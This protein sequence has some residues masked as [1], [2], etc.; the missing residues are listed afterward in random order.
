MGF[1][2]V[3]KGGTVVDGTGLPAVRTDVGIKNGKVVA[4]GNLSAGG[5]R[6]IDAEGKIVAPGFVDIHTHYDAQILWDPLLTCSRWHGTTSVVMGNC[7][8]TLAPCRPQDREFITRIFAG[9]EG[10]S[11]HSL[12]E[13]I[14]W[15]WQ[16]YPEYL[17]RISERQLGINVASM[18]GHT[19]I[20]RFVMGEDAS[21]R[22][23]D[24]DELQQMRGIV[25]E[26]MAAGAF[27][28]TTSLSATHYDLDGSPVPSRLAS[29]GEVL[30]LASA[31]NEFGVG[32]I[33][34]ITQSGVMARDGFTEADRELLTEL[35]LRSGRPVNFN[36]INQNAA[37]PG[38]WQQQIACM[39]QAWKAGAQVYGVA[40]CQRL[41]HMF[42]LKDAVAFRQWPA[43]FKVLPEPND[44]KLSLLVDPTVRSALRE[45]AEADHSRD[46][47]T[48]RPLSIM[49]FPKSKTGK[50]AQYE[51]MRVVDI[52]RQ[53]GKHPVDIIIDWS[54]DEDLEAE[55]VFSG[56]LN[57]DEDEVAQIIRNPLTLVG[58]SD[59][60]AHTD[61]LS[62]SYFS[63]YL[64]THW[65]RDTGFL[66]LDEAIRSL[67]LIPA[68]LYSLWDRGQIREGLPADLVVF[69]LD[70]LNWLP[71]ER[72][73]DFPGAESRLANR[74]EGY[75]HLIVNGRVVMED[76]S[77]TGERPGQVFRSSDYRYNG[78]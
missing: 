39:E 5:A 10:M 32:G 34:I 59:A 14:D 72:L 38:V 16:S 74:A 69:D 31:L 33:E 28:F 68:S 6:V 43:W 18:V 26:A 15:D 25:R 41:D 42:N 19:A 8:F 44:K 67:T 12:S 57:D 1:A 21:T 77:E 70:K 47:P 76:G 7:G 48:A 11:L 22:E 61:R 17:D 35:S 71:T 24:D 29:H 49:S 9:V 62:G 13:G 75:E 63:T 56:V 46:L 23:A 65:V 40:R 30:E 55:F 73:N 51:G 50:Y 37:R 3:V 20:R 53:I 54:L 2:L 58:I 66:S 52:G 45:D 27:G 64:L 78:V 60:G 36:E 4:R